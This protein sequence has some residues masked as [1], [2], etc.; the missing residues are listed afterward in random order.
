MIHVVQFLLV[1]ATL[2]N[3]YTWYFAL[4]T[5]HLGMLSIACD[6][7]PGG[8][9]IY[10]NFS[11]FVFV[12]VNLL[13]V[14]R[15]WLSKKTVI[16]IYRFR[17]FLNHWIYVKKHTYIVFNVM[18]EKRFKRLTKHLNKK[19]YKSNNLFLS[20]SLI[21]FYYKYLLNFFFW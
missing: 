9:Q 15:L 13:L 20:E 8:N 21:T 7:L 18:C 12:D 16:K 3:T 14:F 2:L 17:I 10:A 6:Q 11:S 1:Q 5:F 4:N 19:T